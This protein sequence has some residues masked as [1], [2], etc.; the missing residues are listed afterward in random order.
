MNTYLSDE[1]REYYERTRRTILRVPESR[2]GRV[3]FGFVIVLW[4]VILLLPCA[5]FSLA[6]GGEIRIGHGTVPEPERHPLLLVNL[7]MD[8]DNRGLRFETSS[9]LPDDDN[10]QTAVCVQSHVNYLT[11]ETDGSAQPAQYCDC[12]ERE[13]TEANWSLMDSQQGGCSGQSGS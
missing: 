8:A 10:P 13:T 2:L 4:F 6:F 9:I 12:Y 11:W 5:L 1:E 7:V 3:I